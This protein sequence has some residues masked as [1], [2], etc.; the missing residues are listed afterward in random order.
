[1]IIEGD[2]ISLDLADVK[3]TMRRAIC[4]ASVDYLVGAVRFTLESVP[5]VLIL[6][7]SI[8]ID[9]SMDPSRDLLASS[10]SKWYIFLPQILPGVILIGA[11]LV[12]NQLRA[13]RATQPSTE[14]RLL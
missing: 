2:E 7:L 8:V 3:V 4:I 13:C 14:F 10:L 12:R 11:F 6:P 5:G 1:M 9:T